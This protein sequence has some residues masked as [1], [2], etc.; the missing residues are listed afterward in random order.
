MTE[1]TRRR[2]F[3]TTPCSSRSP[4]T[5]SRNWPTRSRVASSGRRRPSCSASAC[6]S[7]TTTS[8]PGAGAD[9]LDELAERA[10]I[11]R[12]RLPYTQARGG[13]WA[14]YLTQGLYD[15]EGYTMQIDAH[16]RMGDGLGRRAAGAGRASCRRAE[17]MLTGFPPLY[18]V[19]GGVD[20]CSWTTQTSRCRSPWS[21]TGRATAGL[22]HPRCRR[23][24]SSP[25]ATA[26]AVLSGA[27]V[28]TLGRWNVDVRQD[29]E[30]LY[31]GEEIRVD[32]PVVHPRLRPV[33]PAHDGWCGTDCTHRPTRSTSSTI[34]TAGRLAARASVQATTDAAR[35]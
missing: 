24:T 21:T 22:H 17:P 5:A 9:A 30:H 34:P 27:F 35:R 3:P 23:R 2:R 4:P 16:S 25:T 1:P 18:A 12:I 13:C 10:T 11:D 19:D 32:D 26:D 20:S 6:A 8:L 14:R 31:A 28:F 7:S 15:G 33:E 29:P